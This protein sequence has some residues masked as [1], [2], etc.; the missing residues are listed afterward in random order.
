M[1]TSG[2]E[3]FKKNFNTIYF[4]TVRGILS[5]FEKERKKRLCKFLFIL[6]IYAILAYYF[7][8]NVIQQ[9]DIHLFFNIAMAFITIISLLFLSVF[10]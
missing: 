2:I 8:N 7:I 4:N 9:N 6:L 5:S 1:A 3:L 10:I